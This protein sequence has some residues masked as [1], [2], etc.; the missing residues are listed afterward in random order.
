MSEQIVAQLDGSIKFDT[1]LQQIIGVSPD[2]NR[3]ALIIKREN[4]Y[5][6]VV[7]GNLSKPYDDIGSFQFSQDNRHFAFAAKQ[8]EKW[9]LV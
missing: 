8:N 2:L 5:H 9:L 1:P 4:N 3:I 7:D 6:V